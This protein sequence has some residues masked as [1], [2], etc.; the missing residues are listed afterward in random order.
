MRH[1]AKS[2]RSV[3]AVG[4]LALLLPLGA[5]ESVRDDLLAADDPDIISPDAVKSP[6][7]AEAL[8][9]GALSRLRAITAGG[10]GAWLLGGLLVDEWKSSDTFLQ[11]NETDERKV[12]DNNANVQGMLRDLYRP[13]TNA[14][15]AIDALREFKPTPAANIGQMYF[16]MGFA[17]MT[18]AEN[19]CNGIPFGDASTGTVTYGPPISN[20]EAF[21]MALAH[22]DSGLTTTAAT[23]AFS[24]SVRHSLSLAKAR[25]LI[26]L[27]RFADAATAVAA[28]P[29]NYQLNS[30]FSLTAG[31][32]QIWSLN[33]S[34][35]RWTVGDSFDVAGRIRNA[36][37]FASARDPRL[38]V[39][40]TATGTSPAGRGFDNQ[41]NFIYQTLWG[42]TDATPIVSG[43]DA[44]LIEAEAKLQAND[45]AGMTTILNALRTS[46]QS[47]GAITTPVMTALTTPAT[48]DAAIDLYF[49]EKAFWTFGRGQRLPSLRRLVRQYGRTQ[50][51]VFPQGTFF[52]TSTPYGPDVNFPVTRDELNNPE[53]TGC[54][55]R[56]A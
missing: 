17:E 19:F 32:N 22:F 7:G 55:D 2:I 27:G 31:S 5:C 4:G 54:T 16:V 48:K 36:I 44:R 53:F 26:H 35:K 24:V 52:K 43:L 18:L 42:R 45:L 13:R 50:D 37:P 39:I 14:R 56:N 49:R 46:A 33:T 41:T 30:T 10:E 12:Q 1:I 28:V 40:G 23:D 9:I 51:N 6:E 3:A 34:A 25:T 8:R 38:P 29:T 47:L 21:A 11:R 15:E 20:A